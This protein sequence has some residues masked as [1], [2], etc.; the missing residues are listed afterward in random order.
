[1]QYKIFGFYENDTCQCL[2][3]VA[4]IYKMTYNYWYV[5]QSSEDHNIS[6][7]HATSI[8]NVNSSYRPTYDFKILRL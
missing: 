4:Y 1:M 6:G 3:Y 2:C 5:F 8:E 7:V